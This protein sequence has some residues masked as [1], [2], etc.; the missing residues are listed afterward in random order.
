MALSES[1][2]LIRVFEYL[3][4]EMD[5]CIVGDVRNIPKDTSKDI[6]FVIR[7]PQRKKIPGLL[8][9]FCRAHGCRLIQCLKHESV[10][11]YYVICWRGQEEGSLRFLQLD[12]CSDFMNDAR[13]FQTAGELL[14][15]CVRIP[16]CEEGVLLPV[17]SPK[18]AFIYYLVKRIDKRQLT[19]GNGL[20]LSEQFRLDPEG[21]CEEIL[22]FWPEPEARQ[23][24]DAAT[25][26]KWDSIVADEK[27]FR[28]KIKTVSSGKARIKLLEIY[29]LAE[30]MI[31]PTGLIIELNGLPDEQW[32]RLAAE[33]QNH[34]IRGFRDSVAAKKPTRRSL[35]WNVVRAKFVVIRES[36]Y[37]AFL[38]YLRF[39]FDRNQP[40]TDGDVKQRGS[41][42]AGS[43][44]EYM[45]QR[46]AR[47]IN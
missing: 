14:D 3:R 6:D 9:N 40:F 24:I 36:R 22:H 26:G 15:G 32:E 16:S 27:H 47:R 4:A 23:L 17:P 33:L 43:A 25:R 20:Y 19:A 8:M 41:M 1:Q 46:M 37:H 12:F 42:L 13:L 10:A 34:L 35:W 21:A 18:K 39:R 38:P 29:R 45:A 44:I 31:N 28:G 2:M 7:D 11:A 30:R 5:F